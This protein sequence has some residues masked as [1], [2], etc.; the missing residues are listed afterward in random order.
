[1]IPMINGKFLHECSLDDLQ[2]IIDNPAYSENEYLEFKKT[3]SFLKETDPNRKQQAQEEFRNDICEFANAEGGYLIYGIGEDGN[4]IPHEILG[5]PIPDGVDKFKLRLKNYMVSIVPRIPP[6]KF[7]FLETD[8]GAYVVI[9]YIQHDFYAPYMYL[10][11]DN[12]YRIYK[13][14]NNGKHP[15]S[16]TELKT[17]FTQSLSLEEEILRFRQSRVKYFSAQTEFRDQN[18]EEHRY[19]SFFLFHFIPENF[20][21]S[22]YT[23]NLFALEKKRGIN[24]RPVFDMINRQSNIFPCVEGLKSIDPFDESECSLYNSGILECYL[25]LER[26]G[27]IFHDKQDANWHLYFNEAIWEIVKAIVEEYMRLIPT[28]FENT[29]YFACLSFIGCKGMISYFDDPTSNIKRNK[30]YVDRDTIICTPIVFMDKWDAV[31]MDKSMK[32]LQL[33]ADLALGIKNGDVVHSLLDD[34]YPVT[35]K[36]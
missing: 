18:T 7:H 10:G 15:L 14:A 29:R 22:M 12:H 21:N 30:C 32:N 27:W 33:N 19:S 6:V 13:R 17:M 9:I 8:K 11:N 5:V 1:M 24:F 26:K 31:E 23:K 28:I 36:L 4:S 3:F 34:L 20:T 16:Y 2:D 25:P 35:S